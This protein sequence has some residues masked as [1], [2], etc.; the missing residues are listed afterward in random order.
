[1]CGRFALNATGQDIVDF[2][3]LSGEARL[4][5]PLVPRFNVAPTQEHPI[6]RWSPAGPTL[7]MHRWGLLPQWARDRKLAARMINARADTLFEKPAY[8]K[9]ARWRR[10]LVPA[11]GFYEWRKSYDKGAPRNPFLLRPAE[12]SLL[13]LGGIWEEWLDP[14]TKEKVPTFSLVTTDANPDLDFFHDRMPVLLRDAPARAAWLD[15]ETPREWVEAHMGPAPAGTLR[16]TEVGD[17][18]NKVAH[19]D[20][21]CFLPPTGQVGLFG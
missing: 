11:T 12:G 18:V 7:V 5:R 8:R 3:G 14:E 16:A 6:L 13:A 9:A 10:C 17:R 2:F 19:D 15:P 4:P 21:D 1:V 20:P